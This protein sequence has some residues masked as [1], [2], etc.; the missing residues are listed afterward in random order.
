L[1]DQKTTQTPAPAKSKPPSKDQVSRAPEHKAGPAGD[2]TRKVQRRRRS[3]TGPSTAPAAQ[4]TDKDRPAT[5]PRP[6]VVSSPGDPAEKHAEQVARKVASGGSER[7]APMG[8]GT[9]GNTHRAMAAP[10][11]APAPTRP[12]E[13]TPT[14]TAAAPSPTPAVS[15]PA[16]APAGP[17]PSSPAPSSPAPATGTGPARGTAPADGSGPGP[18]GGKDVA[19]TSDL[20]RATQEPSGGEPIPQPTRG[21]LEQRLGEDLGHVRVHHGQ[22]A[23]RLARDISAQAFT[24]GRDIWLASDASPYDVE[25]MAHEVTHVL[26]G[27][28]GTVHRAP[29]KDKKKAKSNPKVKVDGTTVTH[30]GMP[31]GVMTFGPKK[32][33]KFDRRPTVPKYKEQFNKENLVWKSSKQREEAGKTA[34][35]GDQREA[36]INHNKT[37]TQAAVRKELYGDDAKPSKQFRGP[38]G[39]NEFIFL[40]TSDVVGAAVTIPIWNADDKHAFT[41]YQ[42]DHKQEW[43]LGGDYNDV[44]NL[45]LLQADANQASGDYV[46]RVIKDQV[47]RFVAEVA[48]VVESE[49]DLEILPGE[50]HPDNGWEVT[51]TS[52]DSAEPTKVTEGKGT[53]SKFTEAEFVW[54]AHDTTGEPRIGSKEHVAGLKEAK[55]PL[56]TEEDHL[57]VLPSEAGGQVRWLDRGGTPQTSAKDDKKGSKKEGKGSGQT[58]TLRSEFKSRGSA[59]GHGTGGVTEK[60]N[61]KV[62]G[63]TW[64]K[65]GTPA[66]G[67]GEQVGLFTGEAF[68]SEEKNGV[69]Q[70]MEAQSLEISLLSREGIDWGGYYD[71]KSIADLRNKLKFKAFSPVTFN[72]LDFDIADG[73]AGRGKIDPPSLKIL[74]K[75]DIAVVLGG[76]LGVG[77]EAT[78][79]GGQLSLPGPLQVKGGTLTLGVGIGGITADGRLDFEIKNLATGFIEAA[80]AMKKG[81]STSFAL[82]GELNFDTKMFD[83]AK[84]GISYV[85]QKWGVTGE[86]A[87]SKPGKIKGIKSARAKIEITDGDVKADGTFQPD[88]KGI[89]SGHLGLHYNEATG[90][91]ITGDVTLGK[92]FPG[93]KSGKIS[94]TVARPPGAEGW[95]LDATGTAEP[96]IPGVQSQINV[97]YKNGVFDASVTAAYSKG[98]LSGQLMFGATNRP[99]SADGKPGDAPADPAAAKITAYGGGQMTVK[100]TPWLAGTVGVKILPNGEIELMGKVALPD[101]LDIFAQKKLQKELF[102]IGIDIPIIGVAVAGQRIGIFATIQGGAG[103]EASVGPGQLRQL[104]LEV[105]YNPAHEDQTTI[106]GGAQVHVPAMA[107]LRLFVRGALGAGIPVVSAEAGLEVSGELGI[108]GEAAAAVT[109]NWSPTQ[110]LDLKAEACVQAEPVFK[111][112]IAG[113][114]LV[115]ADL[116]IT[117]IELYS[118]RWQLADVTLGSG[119]K[120]GMRLPVHYHEGQPF[121]ISASDVQFDVPKIDPEQILTDLMKRIA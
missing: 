88:I 58:Y 33:L 89:E 30:T 54:H 40:G 53:P 104:S 101:T 116:W 32:T 57:M 118:K 21:I 95:S 16:P 110:G 75:A 69:P 3:D 65:P 84:L 80:T 12:P 112:G 62:T 107:G 85:D 35:G 73:L 115:Q 27:I 15:A 102:K 100:L 18:A 48:P 19:P 51:W 49:K 7:V 113:Y 91:E 79:T 25:L 8:G 67:S 119:L 111:F 77:L 11:P 82:A 39:K 121:E 103:I 63:F 78:I 9:A 23:D 56:S 64:L 14:A 94:A 36:W 10:A 22:A 41:M 114:V 76:D 74:E 83:E 46:K 70:L 90:P 59:K 93:I 52:S 50:V 98:M 13:T 97:A 109:V 106:T 117:T 1:G 26:Q 68:K 28:P 72:A 43:Q 20:A 47:T 4:G 24:Q 61:W 2:P 96:D 60:P 120:L 99:V 71:R 34:V 55:G 87:V 5:A 37:A 81:G 44:K 86:L 31:G 17:A 29:E 38:E 105:H 6:P 66:T 108:Q 45:W 92:G 42:V